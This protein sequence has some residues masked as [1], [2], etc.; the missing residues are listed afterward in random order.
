MKRIYIILSIAITSILFYNIWEWQESYIDKINRLRKE[1]DNFFKSDEKSPI[2]DKDNFFG[3]KYF[4]PNEKWK[5][6]AKIE[7]FE[8]QETISIATTKGEKKKYQKLGFAI[9]EINNQKHK[10]LLLKVPNLPQLFIAFKDATAEKNITYGGGRYIDLPYQK[11]KNELEI[12]FNMAY[13]PYCV[14][15]EKYVCPLPP[16]E[17]KLDIAIEAGEKNY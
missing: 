1:K 6:K 11:D 16:K 8:N 2:L 13:N 5:V 12:D 14:Y 7:K 3:L 17:N 15:N 4:E 10:L 9:F